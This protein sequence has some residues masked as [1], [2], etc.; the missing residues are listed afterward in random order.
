MSAAFSVNGFMLILNKMLLPEYLI[1]G[2]WALVMKW[3]S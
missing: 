1:K 2:K 3:K